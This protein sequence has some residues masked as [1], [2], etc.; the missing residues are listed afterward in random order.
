M[1]PI[2]K[3]E[4]LLPNQLVDGY[5]VY[6]T[7]GKAL[8]IINPKF[9]TNDSQTFFELTD[10]ELVKALNLHPANQTPNLHQLIRTIYHIVE[11]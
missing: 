2:K 5:H 8:E 1:A 4:Q 3:I 10:S 9:D 7:K 11:K 6:L